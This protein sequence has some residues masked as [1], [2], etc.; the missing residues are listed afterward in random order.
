MNNYFIVLAAGRGKRFKS[1]IP[2]QFTQYKGIMMIEHSINKA[3]NSKLFKKIVIVAKNNHFKLLKIRQNKKI[4]FVNGG[5]ERYISSLKGLIA[6]RKFKPKNVFIHDAARPD[7]T[8]KLLKKLSLNLKKNKFV[9][10]YTKLDSSIKI[11][12]NKKFF[13]FDRDKVYLTQTPQCFDFKDL[14]QISKNNNKI[15]T[16]ECSLLINKGLKI[17]FIKGETSNI[18]ITHNKKFKSK[19]ILYGIGFDVHRLV[20]NKKLYLGGLKIKSD[21]GTLGH[22]DGDPVLHSVTDSILGACGM[23]DI[24]QKFSDKKNKYKN[25]RST[26]LLKKVI[27][28]INLN[29][30]IIN[31][32]DINII[33][34]RPK[35]HNYKE[36]MKKTIAKLC[37]IKVSQI[38][39]KGKTT[40]KLGVIGKELAIA[41]EVITSVIK[42]D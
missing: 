38:N 1:K 13:N 32:I 27:A 7:F 29:K 12:K 16:D 41:C 9:V 5:S 33:T 23:E 8:I 40:E 31:N 18:K 36:K 26:I 30:Y 2:K 14:Y 11:K 20:K 22:S 15:V 39:I 42:Y 17:K 10:P 19:K 21:L 25:I 28:E 35:I 34:E 6:I 3:I 37:G 4:I 24:G